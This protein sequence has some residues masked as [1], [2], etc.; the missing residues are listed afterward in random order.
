MSNT[1]RFIEESFPVKEVGIESAREKNI[2]H[3]HISTLHIWWARR[4]LASSRATNYAA[5]I[6]TSENVEE[7]NKTREF[8]ITFSK[9]ENSLDQSMI[10][11]AREDILKANGGEPPKVLDP[12]GGGGA[13]PLEALRLGCETYS[14]D[15]NPVAV[16]I[17]KCTLEYPQKYGKPKPVEQTSRLFGK[18]TKETKSIN[19]L[20]EDVKKWGNWVLEEAKKEIGRFYPQEPDGSIP[21]GYIWARTIPCQRPLCIDQDGQ[22]T[23][24][25]LMRQFWLAKKDNKKVVLFPYVEK[26]GQASCLSFKIVGDGYEKIPENFDPENGTVARAVATCPV[27][28]SPVDANTTR[29]LFQEGKAGQRM[30][31]VV[32]HHPKRQGKRYRIATEK[33]MEIFRE[34]EEYL[35]E[36]R[37]KLMAEWGMDPVPDESIPLMSGVFN[38]PIYGINKWG[39]LFNSRQK[40]ALITFVEKVRKVHRKLKDEGF[41]EEYAKAVVSYLAL[42]LDRLADFGSSLCVLNPTGGRGVVHTFGR[43][44]LPMVWDYAESNPF[45]KQG[46]GWPTAC[47]KNEK[48]INHASSLSEVPP[49]ITQSSASSLPY[50]D[51][52]FEAVFTDPPYYNNVPYADLS[53]FFYVWLKRTVGNLYPELFSTP[54]TPK[55]NEIAEMAGWD[56]ER[57]SYKDKSFFE[58][59]LKKSFQEIHRVLKPDG[60]AVIVYAHK[61]TEGWETMINSLLDS[62][63]IMTGAW[64]LSTEMAG[65]LRAS[66]SAALASSIYIVARKMKRLSTG[67]Y[68]EV[69]EEL[70]QHLNKKLERLWSEGIG[71][72]DFFIAAIGSAIEVFG[73]YEKVMDFEGNTIR[74][75]KMLEDVR[76]IATD[77][78]VRKIL[79]NGFAG[80]I[81]DLT[82]FYVLFRWNYGEAKVQFDEAR[83]LAQS[84]GIDLAHEWNKQGFIRKEKEFIKLLGPQDRKQEE[85][86]HPTELTDVL[87]SVLL[88]W[89]KSKRDEMLELLKESGYGKSEAFYRVAQ[90]ISE[91]LPNESK[92]KKLLDGF[93]AGKERLRE[94]IT[95][96]S[97][98]PK[99][100]KLF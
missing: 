71:G 80:E 44:A 18:D 90:A 78:A 76:G 67:F 62:G 32:L 1:R 33:D 15:L 27:C 85:I 100:K 36:K 12:F 83:K 77:Y 54:L 9:W 34:V 93:L 64:P 30:V 24:I 39:D 45:L 74:A 17:Q 57:Y 70:K 52:F 13:I 60:I 58:N 65:R 25:P 75:D 14:N 35:K 16:L 47:E 3:G 43:Q 66:E 89:E 61:S 31:A 99:Q 48:W 26:V 23:Q 96:E 11:K 6:P 79:H 2:R 92:E 56:K 42:G 68:N 84:C 50:S 28:G 21:V 82:R 10:Q 5:L 55:T 22:S 20:L 8:I 81:S 40:L 97:S 88:Q 29:K 19:P 91:T 98:I 51:N 87:H 73:K 49:T 41:E 94:E 7:W 59:N 4:P 37:E 86:K 38:V 46:A 53:D 63:L 95:K 72:A 69:G